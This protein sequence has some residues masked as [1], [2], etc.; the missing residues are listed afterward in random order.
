MRTILAVSLSALLAAPAVSAPPAKP[1]PEFKAAVEEFKG[2]IAASKA[3][4]VHNLPFIRVHPNDNRRSILLIHG[5]TDSPYYMKELGDIF[6]E[7]GYNVVGIL[8]PG[9][10]TKPEDLHDVKLAQ[11]QAAVDKG[12]SIARRLGGETSIGGFST[13]GALALDAVARHFPGE[14]NHSWVYGDI[15]LFSPAVDLPVTSRVGAKAFCAVGKKWVDANAVEDSEY[16]YRK[17]SSN[18]VCQLIKLIDA[19]MAAKATIT[20]SLQGH[21]V[22]A[23][24]SMADATVKPAATVSLVGDLPEGASGFFDPYDKSEGIAHADVTRSDTNKN[25]S[26][27]KA[28]L[29][30]FVER[31]TVGNVENA[32]MRAPTL[33]KP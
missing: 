7:K 29:V 1:S 23:V 14:K 18:A 11:W 4:N 9:H 6:Y 31:C 2:V 28:N 16:R 5:L 21:G 13:G 26:S 12:L 30:E 20:A 10:G 8:L 27:L 24:Q 25:F 32:K 33:Y 15:Y 22:Y 19:N 3:R 17:M